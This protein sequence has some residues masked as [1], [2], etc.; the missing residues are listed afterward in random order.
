MCGVAA[1]SR[2]RPAPSDLYTPA[3]AK[4]TVALIVLALSWT[5]Q[6][7]TTKSIPPPP[8]QQPG[9]PPAG[10]AAPDGYSPIPQWAGQTKAPRVPVSVP[11]DVE[12][13]STG[14]TNGYSIEF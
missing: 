10:F 2:W 11:Y 7:Q 9:A 14:I 6:G 1:H 8:A 4:A 3:M 12:V 13:V 5:A